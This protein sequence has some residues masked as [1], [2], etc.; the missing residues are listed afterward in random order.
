M[1]IFKDT[2]RRYVRDQLSVRDEIISVGNPTD[3]VRS[4]DGS[5]SFVSINKKDRLKTHNVKLQSGK[6]ITLD[7]GVFYNYTLNKV[8]SQA[9]TTKPVV[10][11]FALPFAFNPTITPFGSKKR[12]SVSSP[13]ITGRPRYVSG[14]L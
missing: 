9:V 10:S 13:L 3:S 11:F 8:A 5:D 4:T 14:T 2:F 1:S 7:P 12:R 6:E